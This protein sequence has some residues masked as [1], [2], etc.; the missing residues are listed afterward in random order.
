MVST[1]LAAVAAIITA[2]VVIWIYA[3]TRWVWHLEGDVLTLYLRC[4]RLQRQII[5]NKRTPT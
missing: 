2:V 1:F 5:D 4:E 3:M